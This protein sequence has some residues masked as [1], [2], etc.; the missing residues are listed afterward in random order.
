MQLE[1]VGAS[2]LSF[3]KNLADV[4]PL[5]CNFELYRQLH[6]FCELTI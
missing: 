2:L 6:S 4:G 1:P 3:A 5:H